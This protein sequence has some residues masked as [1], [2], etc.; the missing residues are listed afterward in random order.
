MNDEQKNKILGF[1]QRQKLT[2]ISTT[3]SERP[4]SALIAFTETKDLEIVFG[5]SD[6][7]R[8]YKNL[9]KNNHVAFV[10]GLDDR[11]TRTTIQYEGLARELEG[12]EAEKYSAIHI[13]KNPGS[14]KYLGD[15]HERHFLVQPTWIRYANHSGDPKDVFEFDIT[16]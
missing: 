6:E 12:D 7:T 4:E 11:D 16:S 14:A 9:R 13:A 15:R 5:T 8:K 1:L 2:V 3:A 10:F